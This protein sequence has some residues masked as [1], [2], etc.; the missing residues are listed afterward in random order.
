VAGYDDFRRAWGQHV[1]DLLLHRGCHAPAHCG[2]DV[3]KA[4]GHI[5]VCRQSVAVRNEGRCIEETVLV[6][7]RITVCPAKGHDEPVGNHLRAAVPEDEPEFLDLPEVPE[8]VVPPVEAIIEAII[9]RR[10]KA[11]ALVVVVS[12]HRGVCQGERQGWVDGGI[13]GG[14]TGGRGCGVQDRTP[15]R[16]CL[17]EFL[18][19][20]KERG[21]EERSSPYSVRVETKSL[22]KGSITYIA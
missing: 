7:V 18:T 21:N 19:R 10:S 14:L 12:G 2:I 3:V 1:E 20:G 6:S 16:F 9:G 17:A 15:V 8:P 13:L 4:G 5:R 11:F 22:P